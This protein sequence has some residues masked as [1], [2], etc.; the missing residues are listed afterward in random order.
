MCNSIFT[1][2]FTMPFTVDSISLECQHC[3]LLI[4]YDVRNTYLEC[5]SEL[6][7]HGVVEQRIDCCRQEVED[8]GHVGKCVVND[9]QSSAWSFC[10]LSIRG[11][12]SLTVERCPADEERH[13]NSH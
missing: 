7:G 11:E 12:N 2:C 5:L 1:R 8:T 10:I 3:S 9:H 6:V 13:H 4:L